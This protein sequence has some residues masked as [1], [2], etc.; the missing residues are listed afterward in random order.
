M[1]DFVKTN[2]NERTSKVRPIIKAGLKCTSPNLVNKKLHSLCSPFD[3]KQKEWITIWEIKNQ[4]RVFILYA[5]AF[6]EV[7]LNLS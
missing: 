2:S 7:G 5:F 3:Y 6:C 4:V 1:Y